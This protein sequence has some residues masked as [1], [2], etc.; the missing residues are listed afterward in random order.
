VNF[1]KSKGFDVK[2]Y[3]ETMIKSLIDK[4]TREIEEKE[5]RLSLL[6]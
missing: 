6:L 3:S 2:S 1:T 4:K 5:E